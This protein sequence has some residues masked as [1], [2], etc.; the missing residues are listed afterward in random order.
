MD[1]DKAGSSAAETDLGDDHSGSA[2]LDDDHLA[3]LKQHRDGQLAE[4]ERGF[5]A[6]LA[7]D[8]YYA[9]AH[10]QLGAIALQVHQARAGLPHLKFALQANPNHGQYW[11]TYIAALATAGENEAA[12]AMLTQSVQIGLAGTGAETL[13]RQLGVAI[14]S[15]PPQ[16]PGQ[17][18]SAA[19]IAELNRIAAS[20]DAAALEAAAKKLTMRFPDSGV[21]WNALGTALLE[22]GAVAEAV[23]PLRCAI[24][25]LPRDAAGF[26][27]LANA[28]KS[29]GAFV[30]AEHAYRHAMRLQPSFPLAHSNLILNMNF[31]AG[32]DAASCVAEA[33]IYGAR[34]AAQA[35]ASGGRHVTWKCGVNPQQLRIGLVSGDFFEHPV[36]FFLEDVL[37]KI[38]PARVSLVAYPTTPKSDALTARIRPH[39]TLWRPIAGLRDRDAAKQIH[40]DGIHIL[41]DLAGHTAQNRLPVFAYRPAPVQVS[42]LGYFATTGVAEM[43]FLL[44]DE[45][46]MPPSS[47]DQFTEAVHLLPDT[48]LCFSAPRDAPAVAPLPALANKYITFGSFQHLPKLND[49]VLTLWAR[50]LAALPASKLRLQL[51]SLGSAMVRDRLAQRLHRAGIPL[52][53]VAMFEAQPRAQYLAAH[54]AIDVILDTFPYPGGTTTCEALWMGVPTLTLAGDR[55]LSRQGASMLHAAGLDRWIARSKN[56]YVEKAVQFASDLTA[57]ADLRAR[58]RDQVAASALFDATAFARHWEDAMWSMWRK[59]MAA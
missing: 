31:V 4:A 16:L 7:R 56:D 27:N 14:A 41:V 25:L 3:S 42:W 34:V 5:R 43:D 38:D 53:R 35:V 54:A 12:R 26:N 32:H 18:P 47:R 2:S 11:L 13:A 17:T 51:G 22:Q 49:E 30:E 29:I 9:D 24:R 15:T 21:A 48:R 6:V 58:L 50:V 37:A 44:A 10:F 40:H 36:G 28:L 45:M 8:P 46:G 52:D 20:Q 19:D 33:R 59:K 57:L 55:L 1:S 23:E 39:F